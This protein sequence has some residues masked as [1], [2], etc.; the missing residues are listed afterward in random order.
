[1]T[2]PIYV[3]IG[4]AAALV[5]IVCIAGIG[6]AVFQSDLFGGA[7]TSETEE[8]YTI[9]DAL[10][11]EVIDER[12]EVMSYLGLPDAFAMSTINVEGVPV[13]LESW[14]Y[15][16]FGTRVDFVDGEVAWTIDIDPVP[17][18]TILPAWYDPLDFEIG[19]SKEQAAAV[20]ASAS[21]AGMS[22]EFIDISDGGP[23]LAGAAALVG[24]QIIIGVH[25][26]GVV[27]IET[28]AMFPVE[29]ES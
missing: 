10:S 7:S 6:Y 15:Y 13:Q 12:G 4:C 24:D 3:A 11:D 9:G 25:E 20:A 8:E 23:E 17:D 1:L 5:A 26:N 14:R 16:G 2:T 22:P 19:M 18:G 21:P 27:Y 29:G 28:I